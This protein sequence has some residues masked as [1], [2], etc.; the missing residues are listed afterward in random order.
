MEFLVLGF[1]PLGQAALYCLA[2]CLR[3]A[4]KVEQVVVDSCVG[5][6]GPG[7]VHAMLAMPLRGDYEF[8]WHAGRAIKYVKVHQISTLVDPNNAQDNAIQHF[9]ALIRRPYL[10]AWMR[11]RR[12]CARWCSIGGFLCGPVKMER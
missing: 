3:S 11:A 8:H 9:N 2:H 1:R 10:Q 12:S 6:A 7:W 5:P 4:H